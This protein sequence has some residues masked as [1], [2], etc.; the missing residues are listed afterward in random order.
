[1]KKLFPREILVWQR[2]GKR[3]PLVRREWSSWTC[4]HT[5]NCDEKTRNIIW[6]L[7][8]PQLHHNF[9][10]RSLVYIFII[11]RF[12]DISW[13]VDVVYKLKKLILLSPLVLSPLWGRFGWGS[14][15]WHYMSVN[16]FSSYVSVCQK[17][18]GYS[19]VFESEN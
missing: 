14:C 18:I 5:S 11:N 15:S 1:M 17:W 16:K 6:S 10:L 8:D 7:W 3:T 12:D 19:I 2:Y 4:W 13:N 9:P